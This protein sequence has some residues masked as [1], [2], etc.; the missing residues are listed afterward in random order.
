MYEMISLKTDERTKPV[1]YCNVY[2]IEVKNSLLEIV[3][4][5]QDNFDDFRSRQI[6]F[7]D[8]KKALMSARR[9]FRKNLTLLEL[10]ICLFDVV[11]N[12]HSENLTKRQL[13]ILGNIADYISNEVTDMD[14]ENATQELISAGLNP[15]PSLSG[16]SEI[17]REQ[18]EI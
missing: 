15:L 4:R 2:I 18:G 6:G 3:R 7:F 8:F 11:E 1:V 13:D 14:I 5:I 9:E 12:L 16:L 17:Y 10:M